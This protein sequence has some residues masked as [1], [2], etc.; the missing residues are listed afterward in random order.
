M[1]RRRIGQAKRDFDSS[2]SS[3]DMSLQNRKEE[4]RTTPDISWKAYF[5][6]PPEQ[7]PGL[8]TLR[9][10]IADPSDTTIAPANNSTSTM[11]LISH[12]HSTLVRRNCLHHMWENFWSISRGSRIVLVVSCCLMVIEM[13]LTVTVLSISTKATCDTNLVLFLYVYGVRVAISL[14]LVVYQYL[15]PIGDNGFGSPTK[16][17]VVDV[18]ISRFVDRLRLYLDLFHAFWFIL[19]N[20]WVF[21]S[22]TCKVTAPYVYKL[23]LGF[24]IFGYVVLSL[25][26]LVVAGVM[27][28]LPVV[29]M[30][31]NMLH[32]SGLFSESTFIWA[33][34][35]RTD[36]EIDMDG[37]TRRH[38]GYWSSDDMGVPD[39]VIAKIALVKF[40]RRMLKDM[41]MVIGEVASKLDSP[42]R[43]LRKES[44]AKKPL[45]SGNSNVSLQ[46]GSVGPSSASILSSGPIETSVTVDELGLI[47]GGCSSLDPRGDSARYPKQALKTRFLTRAASQPGSSSKLFHGMKK[48]MGLPPLPL[49][50][51]DSTLS[52]NSRGISRSSSTC[53]TMHDGSSS[54]LDCNFI[55]TLDGNVD[56]KLND[57]DD[58]FCVICLNEYED[59]DLLRKLPCSHQFHIKCTDE[60]LRINKTCPLCLANIH[61]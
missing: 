37:R 19:G 7:I 2:P 29:L 5:V 33:F 55:E 30:W 12:P 16:N 42:N 50:R 54:N 48:D 23:S 61:D 20:W 9:N 40:R 8:N 52:R 49:K 27:F 28:C 46:L 44:E 35:T 6:G 41:E 47:G 17:I 26:V 31:T 10:S 22:E 3:S 59:G 32:W 14:P 18:E 13:A 38:H 51:E 1:H 24:I 43:T 45:L 53:S 15:H 34:D 60:W 36:E 57:D 25:P 11:P 39:D 56:K 21:S 58:M 4:T